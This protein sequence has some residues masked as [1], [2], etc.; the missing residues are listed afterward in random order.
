MN[1]QRKYL[2]AVSISLIAALVTSPTII[3]PIF[4]GLLALGAL[5]KWYEAKY[6]ER[7]WWTKSFVT[8]WR[9]R[10]DSDSSD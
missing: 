5:V 2:A 4:F 7:P 9:E 1:D 6:G 10:G 8:L 3:G